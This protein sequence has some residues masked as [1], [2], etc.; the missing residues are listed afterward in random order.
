MHI[1]LMNILYMMYGIF[2]ASKKFNPRVN[3]EM[4]SFSMT[5]EFGINPNGSVGLPIVVKMAVIVAAV[6]ISMLA[7]G[8]EAALKSTS[9]KPI[10]VTRKKIELRALP[11]PAIANIDQCK[12]ILNGLTDQSDQVERVRKTLK[13][14]LHFRPL[15]DGHMI[16]RP[17]WYADY[18]DIVAAHSSMTDDDIPVLVSL[19]GHGKLTGGTRSIGFGAL[20]MF[21]EKALPCIDAGMAI[22]PE[23]AS[24]L[25]AVKGNVD[26]SRQY[27]DPSREAANSKP[28]QQHLE[29][30]KGGKQR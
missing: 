6:S 22:Y 2:F 17:G 19:I 29:T 4:H 20:G 14:N 15:G 18:S 3:Q 28:D 8:E 13:K 10:E 5:S 9:E 7:S 12:Q 26:V 30:Q 16:L 11:R 24:D 1:F 21:G 23:H 27:P 25:F